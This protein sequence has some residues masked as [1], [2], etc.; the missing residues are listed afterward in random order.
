MITETQ[1]LQLL[2]ERVSKLERQN[3]RLKQYAMLILIA[4]A[5]LLLMGQGKAVK[6]AP[7]K[8]VRALEAGKFVLQDGQG[9]RR[10]E[11]GLIAERPSLVFYD[12][13]DR[14]MLSVGLDAEGAG[15]VLYDDQ[16][17][18]T[19]ALSSTPT[20]PVLALFHSGV[21]RLNL[22]VTTQG[23]ALGLV[24]KNGDARAALG[25]TADDNAFLH[26]FGAGERGGAQL[27]ASPDRTVLRFFD[28]A[29]KAR[30]V[31]GL[32]EKE[33]SPGFVLNDEAGVAR[34]IMMLT[35]DG[36]NLELFD[37]NRNRIWFA[38]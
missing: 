34:A 19:A 16:I 5:S 33:G 14:A 9:K 18:K 3:R 28:S 35:S 20:G 1:A 23:P 15:L 7:V 12:S 30:S 26:L 13:T 21:K 38:R 22:S 36:P 31:L 32:L 10:A 6:V 2:S 24:G 4:A 8:A 17:R 29:D 37:R 11:L 25:L 27:L